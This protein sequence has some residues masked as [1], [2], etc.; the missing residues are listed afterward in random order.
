ME[1]S[2]YFLI[3]NFWKALCSAADYCLNSFQ[4]GN[5]A[6]DWVFSSYISVYKTTNLSTEQFNQSGKGL[7]LDHPTLNILTIPKAPPHSA[8]QD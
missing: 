8:V 1:K 6:P 3:K 5:I 2:E 7:T 4:S